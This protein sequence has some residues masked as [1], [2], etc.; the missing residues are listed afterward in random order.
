[1]EIYAPVSRFSGSLGRSL[2]VVFMRDEFDDFFFGGWRRF[3]DDAEARRCQFV[4][5]A[6][7]DRR[8]SEWF[9]IRSMPLNIFHRRINSAMPRPSRQNIFILLA[10]ENK[11]STKCFRWLS[12]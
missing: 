3:E 10:E 4:H 5:H 2:Y 12:D 11:I 6:L 7:I 8:C 1:L 9:F